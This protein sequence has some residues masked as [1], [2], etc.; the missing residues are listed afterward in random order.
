MEIGIVTLGELLSEP[1]VKRKI[2]PRQRLEEILAAAQLAEEAG[3]EVFGAENAQNRDTH[4]VF[5]HGNEM[6]TRSRTR[7]SRWGEEQ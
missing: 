4:E 5:H 1:S 6:H 3:L 7:Q 2:S